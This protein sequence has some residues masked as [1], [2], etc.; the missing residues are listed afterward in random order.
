MESPYDHRP[1]SDHRHTDQ[2]RNMFARRHSIEPSVSQPKREKQSGRSDRTDTAI[3]HNRQSSLRG[4]PTRQ[5]VHHIGKAVL[6]K[7]PRN[8]NKT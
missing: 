3:S 7:A 1:S 8:G 2:Y 5:S 4:S 6:V